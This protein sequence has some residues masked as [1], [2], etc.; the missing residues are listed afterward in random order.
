MENRVDRV[1]GI[2]AGRAGGIRL[3]AERPNLGACSAQLK[4]EE[5]GDAEEVFIT[6]TKRLFTRCGLQLGERVSHSAV[7]RSCTAEVQLEH[8]EAPR[9]METLRKYR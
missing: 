4:W 9:G 2:T 1:F 8:A 7:A 3:S 5:P 6:R